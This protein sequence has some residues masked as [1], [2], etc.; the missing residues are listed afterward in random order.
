MKDISI[1]TRSLWETSSRLLAT[2]ANEGLVRISVSHTDPDSSVNFKIE[3]PDTHIGTG[4]NA[5]Q[6]LLVGV[7]DRVCSPGKSTDPLLPLSPVDLQPPIVAKLRSTHHLRL[8]SDLE[9]AALFEM[10]FP[11]LDSASEAK[12]QIL[13]ELESSARFQRKRLIGLS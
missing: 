8:C 12:T 7:H 9:P 13:R 1:K 2:L 5:L 11:W 6:F 10:I 3:A 4:E